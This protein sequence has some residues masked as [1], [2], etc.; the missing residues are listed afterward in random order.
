MDDAK[1]TLAQVKK[2]VA[3]FVAERDWQQFHSPKNISMDIAVEAAELME[4]FLWVDKA[5]SFEIVD[6][7]RKGIEEEVGD[8]LMALAIFCNEANIDLAKAF[9]NKLALTK[10]RYPIDKAKG[11][12]KKYTEI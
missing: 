11:K 8:I 7:K 3:E 9:H 10:K 12:N 5:E 1:T 2:A 4:Y 6:K